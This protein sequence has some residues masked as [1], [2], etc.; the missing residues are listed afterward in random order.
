MEN[1]FK[2]RTQEVLFIGAILLAFI[3]FYVETD[4]YTPSFP[5]MVTYFGTDEDSIQLLLSVNFLGLCLSCLFF[6]PASDA[7]GRKTILATGLAIFMLG[8]LGC[9]AA[10]SLNW[11]VA[12]RFFQGIG[13]GSIVSAGMATFFDVYPPERSSRLVAF[14]NGTVGGMMAL[15][16]L[17]GNWISIHQGWRMNFYVIAAL[18]TLAFASICFFIHETLPRAKRAPLSPKGIL[19]NYAAVLA[20]FPF[21]AH[22][23][24][25]T[26]MFSVVIVF[27]A[28]LSLI[29]VDYLHV[30]Q[31][32]F[33]YYQTAIM[34]AFFIGS[35]SGTYSIKSLGMLA[36][37]Q[38]GNGCYLVGIATLAGLSSLEAPSPLLLILAMSL[39]SFG[40]ALSMTIYFS[41]S[42]TYVAEHLKG[43]AMA[44]TQSFRLLMTAGLVGV[45]AHQFDG[46]T[47]P[48]STLALV[49]TA[50][51]AVLYGLLFRKKLH[52]VEA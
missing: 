38:L 31:E 14:C 13:C 18:A 1:F 48:V 24:I 39:A 11:M 10:T 5:E 40:S 9:A 21:M 20:N 8:S 28:N 19:L 26:L 52:K 6:G 47:R 15:A 46:S 7:Y 42:I 50:L 3:A 44:L 49:C 29:F 32:A 45:A 23:L 37:K 16:P 36:T 12:C 33:G 35:M 51:C 22:T 4:I 30:P 34:G 2:S 43:S 17:I 41:Y 25:W 27:I